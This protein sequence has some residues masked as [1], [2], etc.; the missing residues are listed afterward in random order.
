MD[1]FNSLNLN[2]E[3]LL[4]NLKIIKNK[5]KDKK[6]CAMVKANAYGHGLKNVVLMLRNVVDFFG[7]ANTEEALE[8][9]QYSYKSKILICGNINKEKL[10]SIILSDISI[11]VFSLKDLYEIIKIAKQTKNKAKIHLKLNT[12][13]NRLGF[14][15]EKTIKKAINIIE[16]NKEYLV[17]EGV[18][19]HL[20]CSESKELS[21]KQYLKFINFLNLFKNL[22]CINIHLENSR[23]L[24]NNVDS[25]NICNMV[26]VGISLYGLSIENEKLKPVLSLK[27]KIIAK[28]KVCK[29]EFVGYGKEILEN[30]GVV[31]ILPIGYGDGILR[32]YKN[33]FVYVNEKPCKILNVCMDMILIDLTNTNAKVGDEVTII[34]SDNSKINNANILSKNLNTISYEIVTNLKHNRLNKIVEEN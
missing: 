22:S 26:R 27:S 29:E 6:I 21:Q 10:A 20:F 3:N 24:F 16:N 17:L 11:S 4:N 25:F 9:R 14:K 32:G 30:A 19:S 13:M 12:G 31:G 34:S 33:S 23:G 18:F 7:V 1:F 5:A 15:D 28:Q 8:V 2:K